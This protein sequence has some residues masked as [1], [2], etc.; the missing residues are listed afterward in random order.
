[1]LICEG[2]Y[3]PLDCDHHN[4]QPDHV[5][6]DFCLPGFLSGM[7]CHPDQPLGL[8]EAGAAAGRAA[9]IGSW[10]LYQP[11]KRPGG[12]VQVYSPGDH[13]ALGEMDWHTW[14]D[15]RLTCCLSD[16][17]RRSYWRGRGCTCARCPAGR[18]R[19]MT[20]TSWA[21]CTT[22]PIRWLTLWETRACIPR[23]PTTA[24]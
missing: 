19:G 18:V 8:E 11:G 23:D 12:A 17:L 10:N 9:A 5:R 6:G 14:G 24:R 13:P 20:C 3:H 4:P 16:W 21:R 22:I 1:M 7:V 2:K 15:T